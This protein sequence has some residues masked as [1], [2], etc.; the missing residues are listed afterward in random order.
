MS[1]PGVT[2]WSIRHCRP[3]EAEALLALWQQAEATPSVT[4]AVEQIQRAIATA[5]ACVL[6]VEGDGQL[7]GS[8]IGGFD[9]WRGNMYRLVVHPNYRRKGIA[10][11]LVLE[12]EKHLLQKGA[13]RITALVEKDHSWATAFWESVGYRLD[14]RMARYAKNL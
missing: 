13:K 10:C 2:P 5:S 1:I 6:V 12:A 8:I 14:Q 3:E 4:D 11:A 9:G 7:I